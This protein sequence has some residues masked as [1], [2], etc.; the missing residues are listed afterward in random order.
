MTEAETTCPY[1][2]IPSEDVIASLGPALLILPNRAH[3]SP[4]DGGH[5]VV[6][7]WRHVPT[8]G[9]L[10]PQEMLAIDYGTVIGAVALS[11]VCEASWHNFQDNGNWVADSPGKRHMHMH[12]Y[13]RARSAV[14]QPFG[15]AL[16]FPKKE[17]RADWKVPGLS[18]SQVEQVRR[19]AT[20]ALRSTEALRYQ[21]ALN[22]LASSDA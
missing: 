10:S 1:C 9:A 6:I 3:V 21:E 17:D 16:R 12:V 22:V 7:P 2:S 5:L 13:G 4:A 14:D 19:V 18:A 20:Q 11:R 15:E 8:R